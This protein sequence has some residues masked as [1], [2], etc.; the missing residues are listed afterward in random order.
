MTPEMG[1]EVTL[2]K[3]C[4]LAYA[5]AGKHPML[6]EISTSLIHWSFL[7]PKVGITTPSYFVRSQ[8]VWGRAC[9]TNCKVV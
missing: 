7:I 5:I 4:V 3:R 2:V 6:E 1:L 9:C 8:G